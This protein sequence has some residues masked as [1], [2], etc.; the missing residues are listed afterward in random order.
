VFQG[1]SIFVNSI[2]K[3][4]DDMFMSEHHFLL[5]V[6]VPAASYVNP[7]MWVKHYWEPEKIQQEKVR[8]NDVY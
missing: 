6:S 3:E 4:V 2:M 8:Y 1:I 7:E 5:G